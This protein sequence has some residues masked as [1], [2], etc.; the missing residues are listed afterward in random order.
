LLLTKPVAEPH[1]VYPALHLF[2][3]DL[4]CLLAVPLVSFRLAQ[5]ESRSWL[6]IVANSYT[7]SL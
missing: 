3:V 7:G 4:G 2:L 5:M 6:G 1:L